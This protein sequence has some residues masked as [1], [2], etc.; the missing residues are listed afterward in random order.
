[1]RF[2]ATFCRIASDC[3]TVT[4]VLPENVILLD[5]RVLKISRSVVNFSMARCDEQSIKIFF[6]FLDK[7]DGVAIEL[8]HTGD[9]EIIPRIDGTILGVHNN[10]NVKG[11]KRETLYRESFMSFITGHIILILAT[12]ITSI[13]FGLSIYVLSEEVYFSNFLVGVAG[14]FVLLSMGVLFTEYSILFPLLFNV[15]F[16]RLPY[17]KPL[18]IQVDIAPH[19]E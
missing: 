12:I 16:K 9:K 18:D 2:Y 8:K 15:L 10:I 4:L 11:I 1:L 5:F 19:I 6:N 14:L 7:N 17:P 3:T 13:L